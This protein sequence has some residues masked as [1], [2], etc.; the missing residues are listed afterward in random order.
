MVSVNSIKKERTKNA[1]I[2][3]TV[4]MIIENGYEKATARD[5]A[6]K[7]GYTTATLYKHMSSL[8][9]VF[10]LVRNKIIDDLVDHIILKTKHSRTKVIE[11]TF[12]E[13]VDYIVN[14]PNLFRFLF[15]YQHQKEKTDFYEHSSY[16][17]LGSLFMDQFT[18]L[19]A[20]KGINQEVIMIMN[21]TIFF[22]VQG[23]L[24]VYLS[25]NYGFDQ[26]MLYMNLEGILKLVLGD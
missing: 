10:W 17:E 15:F 16:S 24:M 11:K 13:Y 25:N 8:D 6:S 5:I 3:T 22:S 19:G 2:D 20:K 18:E 7:T 9:N 4:E 14:K 26:K 23:M 1:F 12:K 21:S